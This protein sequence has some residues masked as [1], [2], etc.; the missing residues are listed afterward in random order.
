MGGPLTIFDKSVAYDFKNIFNLDGRVCIVTGGAGFLGLQFC[1]AIAEMGGIPII[2]DSDEAS[3]KLA[4]TKLKKICNK[5]CG[6]MSDVT[7]DKSLFEIRDSILKQ[8]GKIDV[9]IN[10]AALTRYSIDGCTVEDFFAPFENMHLEIWQK[11]M[12]VNVTGPMICSKIFGGWMAEMKLGGNIIN[13]G[14]DVGVISPDQRIYMPDPSIGYG[15]VEFNTPIFY[16]IS[17]AAIIHMTK[18]LATYWGRSGVRV[19]AIS[20]A[21]VSR[22]HN[23]LFEKKLAD[24]IPMGRMGKMNEYKGAVIFLASD[25][26]SFITGHNLLIDGGRT[27]W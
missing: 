25:A 23:E 9:L 22:G 7:D 18:H 5:A 16:S 10:N 24:L 6:Y 8:F 12:A 2:I 14:S 17:K 15:G 19:N 21:G 26:S 11:A 20:P 4:T 3:I 13:I 27:I 1:E